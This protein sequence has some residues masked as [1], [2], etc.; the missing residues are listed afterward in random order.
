LSGRCRR[1]EKQKNKKE[2][3]ALGRNH[4]RAAS[5]VGRAFDENT[6]LRVAGW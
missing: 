1:Y 2:G 5:F 4:D 3:Y 6:T